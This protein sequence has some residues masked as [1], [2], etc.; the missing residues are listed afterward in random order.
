M[1]VLAVVR[2]EKQGNRLDMQ[3]SRILIWVRVESLYYS[4]RAIHKLRV[5][6][7]G[8]Q[9]KKGTQNMPARTILRID[10]YG[11]KNT[12]EIVHNMI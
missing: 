12:Q 6:S 1:L 8:F 5:S 2:W 10:H 11:L 7:K 4:T 3:K 9:L